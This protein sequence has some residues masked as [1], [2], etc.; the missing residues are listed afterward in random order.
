MS[1]EDLFKTCQR[2]VAEFKTGTHA[3]QWILVQ[4]SF[5]CY[6]VTFRNLPLRS[7]FR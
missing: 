3:V 2:Q 1:F 5:I 7:A 4:L 6:F